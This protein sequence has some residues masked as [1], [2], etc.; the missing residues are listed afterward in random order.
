MSPPTPS[1][2]RDTL[3]LSLAAGSADAAGYLTLGH[4]FTSNMTGNVVLLG[5]AIGQGHPGDTARS[6]FVLVLF[7]LGFALGVRLDRGIRQGDWPRLAAR[8][9]RLEKIALLLFALG[10]TFVPRDV[11]AI[12]YALL[13]LLAVAMGLQSAVMNRLHAPGV[14]TTAITTTIS[15]LVSGLVSLAVPGLAGTDGSAIRF[16]AG[17]LFL[18]CLGAAISGLLFVHNPW[19]A[20]WIP[21]AA[22]AFVRVPARIQKD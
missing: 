10:W 13:A 1:A 15:A 19:L 16:Q 11:V 22:A 20:G 18:Y 7:M 9:I 12:Q 8:L 2:L 17:V 3:L 6:L 21:I 5:I 4:V 14:G